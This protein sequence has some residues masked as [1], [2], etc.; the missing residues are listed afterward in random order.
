MKKYVIL[1]LV[2]LLTACTTTSS[3]NPGNK[4]WQTGTEGV[5]MSFLADNPPAEVL[6]SQ[7]FNI[8]V[9]YA[10]KGTHD[11]SAGNLVFYLTGYDKTILFGGA[12]YKSESTGAIGGKNQFNTQGSQAAYA[13]WKTTPRITDVPDVDSFKQDL[14]L[15]A[16]YSY[17]TTANPEVCLDPLEYE[18]VAAGKCDFDVRELGSSQ[19]APIAVTDVKLKTTGDK[20]YFEIHFQNKGGGIPYLPSKG[21]TGCYNSLSLS[22]VNMIKLTKVYLSNDDFTGS[23]QPSDEVRLI[24]GRGFAVCEK[25]ISGDSHYVGVMNIEVEYYYRE[26]MSKSITVINVDR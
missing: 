2:V 26:T 18:L 1:C 7:D 24:N 3:S 15:T 17:S 14:T 9:E 8:I 16:C 21:L 22:D 12:P 11:I 6:S 19:G 20:A 13:K 10:N 23:C 4:N 5:R 25:K